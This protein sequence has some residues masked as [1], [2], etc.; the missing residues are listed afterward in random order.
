MKPL[1]SPALKRLRR[2]NPTAGMGNDVGGYFALN[3]LRI[4]ASCSDGWDHVSVSLPD[5]FP[6]WQEM[7]RVKDLFF[8]DHEVVMQLH[9]PAAEHTN[10]HN[11]CLHLWK[12]HNMLIPQPPREMV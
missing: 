12:P 8:Y 9:V 10:I 7:C 3:N 11:Y 6:T 1:N 4:I 2:K 5:R